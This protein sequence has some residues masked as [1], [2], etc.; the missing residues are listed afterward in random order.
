[1]QSLFFEFQAPGPWNLRGTVVKALSAPT[2][3]KLAALNT[4]KTPL[5]NRFKYLAPD[6]EQAR[7]IQIN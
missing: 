7:C 3:V 4:L 1:M 2:D 6:C 5:T